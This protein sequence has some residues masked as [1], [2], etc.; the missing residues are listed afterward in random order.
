MVTYPIVLGPEFD[1]IPDDTEETLVGSFIHQE[2]IV[3]TY[4]GLKVC[5]RRRGLPWFVSNQLFLV[6]PRGNMIP[7]R[8]I[9]PDIAVFPSLEVTNPASLAVARHGAP[10]LVIEVASPST[11]LHNDLNLLDPDG[12]PRLYERIGVEEYLVYDPTAEAVGVEVWAQRRGPSGFIPWEPEGD[13]RWHSALGVSFAPQGMRLRVYDH[14]GQL[15]PSSNEFDAMLAER[16][17]ELAALREQLRRLSDEE[18]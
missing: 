15:V 6:I 7:P 8:R 9:A 18:G 5:A 3:T 16:D 11:G 13:G 14:A 2:T 17:Q 4:E 12:K 10:A 1:T